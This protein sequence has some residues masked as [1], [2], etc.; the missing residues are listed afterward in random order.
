MTELITS[1]HQILA[2]SFVIVAGDIKRKMPDFQVPP[3]LTTFLS[4]LTAGSEDDRSSPLVSRESSNLLW[5]A[6]GAFDKVCLAVGE[7]AMANPLRRLEEGEARSPLVIE[8]GWHPGPG[9][10]KRNG[11]QFA[12]DL[13]G[14]YRVAAGKFISPGGMICS[15]QRV[16]FPAEGSGISSVGLYVGGVF[17]EG[18]ICF[19]QGT[20]GWQMLLAAAVPDSVQNDRAEPRALL[21]SGA[22]VAWDSPSVMRLGQFGYSLKDRGF[23]SIGE[24]HLFNLLTPQEERARAAS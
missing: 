24:T 11:V 19:D 22:C 15:G 12:K 13:S 7:R 23:N 9:S 14:G 20:D 4:R 5:Q 17:M 8:R 2:P 3:A 10:D 6:A 21:W 18:A 1:S 16:S